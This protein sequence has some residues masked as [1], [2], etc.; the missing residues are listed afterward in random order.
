MKRLL[1]T[2]IAMAL[3]ISLLGGCN[4]G[5]ED[6]A[7]SGQHMEAAGTGSEN[8][9]QGGERITLTLGTV[10]RSRDDVL[11]TVVEAYNVRSGKYYVEIVGY[12]PENFDNAIMTASVDRFKMELAT[13]KGTD[14]IDLSQLV[15]DELGYGGI[16][17][18][19]NTFLTPEE[20]QERY[21]T[22]ILDAA[23]TGDALYEMAP[24][25][26]L[27]TIVGDSSR[28]G[29]ENGWTLEE[30]LESF[31]KNDKGSEALTGIYLGQSVAALLTSY[32]LEEFVDWKTGKA[33]FC[34]QK[35]YEIL[36]FGAGLDDKLTTRV[37]PTRES[38]ASGIHLAYM[39]V[40]TN[41][42]DVQYM[43]WL[44]GGNMAVKGFPSGSG[45]GVA[46]NFN[47]EM[48]I[49][50]N[51]QYA[52]GAWDFLQFYV[53]GSW[54][55]ENP[56]M[57][58]GFPLERQAFEEILA[59][60]MVQEYR[61]GEPIPKNVN[62]DAEGPAIYAATEEEVARVRELIGL[63]DRRSGDNSVISQIIDEEVSGYNSGV[64]TAEQT[65]EKI[66]NRVQLYLDE[67]K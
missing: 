60:A 29:T 3:G 6:A 52:E 35:F 42:A 61:D 24:S 22:N 37:H 2:I 14:I 41:V 39:D 63:V 9:G 4:S 19:L 56:W 62:S 65:A 27:Y 48:G 17:A 36:E 38:I 32:S 59:D 50:A 31:G 8:Q 30:M 66:Q 43:D 40:I 53:E 26:S 45:T 5:Q 12:L 18:D 46:A 15:P 13:G 23:Q 7:V 67:Q 47:F 34:N 64:L 44:F 20:R 11:R 28:L 57:I 21:L 51:S 1:R 54:A 55:E 10:S 33:D 16:L 49:N 58:S 25:F